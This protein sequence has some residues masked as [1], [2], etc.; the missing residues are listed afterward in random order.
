[1]FYVQGFT[2]NK[3]SPSGWLKKKT[4]KLKLFRYKNLKQQKSYH[5][6]Y[7]PTLRW[8]MIDVLINC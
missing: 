3:E 8:I 6:S 4:V 5:V 1:M 2:N 7:K